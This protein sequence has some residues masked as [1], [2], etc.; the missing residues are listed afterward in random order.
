MLFYVLFKF[1]THDFWDI[2]KTA[3]IAS[4]FLVG[5]QVDGEHLIVPT[6]VINRFSDFPLYVC[7]IHQNGKTT[8]V[9]NV[10]SVPA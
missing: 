4:L 8:N 7:T 3:Q 6:L 5:V 2:K 1:N 10:Q 9:P